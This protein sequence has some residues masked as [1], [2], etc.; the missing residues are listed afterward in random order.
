MAQFGD[1]RMALAGY[2]AGEGRV[3]RALRRGGSDWLR[4]VPEETR[5]YVPAVLRKV[6]PVEAAGGIRMLAPLAPPEP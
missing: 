3:L 2:N 4:F 5:R 6:R 1:W